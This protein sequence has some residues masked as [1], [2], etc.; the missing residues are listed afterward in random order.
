MQYV[1]HEGQQLYLAASEEEDRLI[2]ITLYRML[3]LEHPEMQLWPAQRHEGHWICRDGCWYPCSCI[4][5]FDREGQKIT[6]HA[7]T[8]SERPGE[9][10]CLTVDV[11]LS[12][13]LEDALLSCRWHPRKPQDKEAFVSACRKILSAEPK[14]DKYLLAWIDR[15]YREIGHKRRQWEHRTGIIADGSW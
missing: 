12:T 10:F 14:T 7:P 3:E 9:N 13:M 6:M 11:A 1:M 5:P 2:R 8:G 4:F 15:V